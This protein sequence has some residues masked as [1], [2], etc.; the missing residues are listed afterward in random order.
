MTKK[1]AVI[2]LGARGGE[3][4]G[5]Y[6][7]K[8][9]DLAKIVAIADIDPLKRKIYQ[10]KY[11][12][13]PNQVFSNGK[14]LLNQ[15]LDLD[16]VIIATPDKLHYED[17]ILALD[18]GYH[19]LLEKP[20]SPNL[21]ECKQIKEKAIEKNRKVILCHVLRYAPIYQKTKE[22]IDQNVIGDI[23]LINQIEHIGYW[24]FAHSFV[25][26]NWR[27]KEESAPIV[28]AKT[29]HDFDLILWFM[30][31]KIQSVSSIGDLYHFNHKNK[32][33]GATSHCI[34]GCKVKDHCPYDAEKIYID[35]FKTY[36]LNHRNVWPFTVLHPK[37]SV[38]TLKE[39][40]SGPYGRCVYQS[41]NNVMDHQLINMNFDKGKMAH[42]TLSAFTG[43][44]HRELKIM[45]TLGELYVN[46][47]KQ[48]IELRRF[49]GKFHIDP[50]IY[51]IKAITSNLAGH[52]GGDERLMKDFIHILDQE[53]K[54]T[55]L[56]SIERTIDSHYIAF[57][58]EESRMK[59][60]EI[61]FMEGVSSK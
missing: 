51:D 59:N 11:Q 29:C 18:K 17:T 37:P 45:G 15:N 32:P 13:D 3:V 19:V 24:H 47:L 4:Y 20:I 39:A 31:Q 49:D 23:V 57:M 27:N 60:G 53:V 50:V 5:E 10:D 48:T 25:R 6:I 42:L 26:G 7:F 8:N 40:L 52:G 54:H 43:T 28:L 35:N 21:E 46:D 30:N 38:E 9:R 41:D 36:D 12:L 14:D 16:A 22:L 44:T 61:I 56:T 33:E 55:H 34:L 58:A 1:I 2:G